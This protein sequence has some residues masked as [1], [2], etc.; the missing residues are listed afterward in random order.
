MP[1]REERILS[2]RWVAAL[3]AAFVLTLGLVLAG[4]GAL[5]HLAAEPERTPPL[6]AMPPPP[7]LDPQLA[8]ALAALRAREHARLASWGWV[9]RK[10]GIARIPVDEA[11]RLVAAQGRLPHWPEADAGV[12]HWELRRAAPP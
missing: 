11:A 10:R 1:E 3:A 8:R 4:A 5:M 2:G 6:A 12:A 7:R 9:D